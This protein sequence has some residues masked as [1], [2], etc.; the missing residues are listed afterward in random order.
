MGK[1]KGLTSIGNG[2]KMLIRLWGALPYIVLGLLLLIIIVLAGTC[3]AKKD[4]L[5]AEKNGGE[6]NERPPVNIV[7]LKLSPSSIRDSINLP[8]I[9]EPWVK[10]NIMAE[11]SGKV[12][13]KAVEEGQRVTKG[14]ILAVIDNRDYVNAYNS[15]KAV[16]ETAQASFNRFSKLYD[17]QLAT[18]S[19]LDTARASM[20]NAR[21]VMDNAALNVERCQIRAPFTGIVNNIFFEMGLY[22][23]VADPVAEMLQIDRVKVN[24]GI[25][26]SDV[27][28]VRKIKNFDIRIDALSGKTFRGIMHFLSSTADSSARLYSLKLAVENPGREILPDMFAR[29]EIVKRE[30]SDGIVIPLYAVI[31]RN[32]GHYA[33]VVNDGRA[34]I[35][36]VEIGL[37]ED[38]HV[39][40]TKGLSPDERVIVIGQ[41]SVE[42]EQKVNV[43]RDIESLEEL[44]K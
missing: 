12:I 39:E 29:I 13:Q 38:W 18:K 3:S 27:E 28:A 26:E 33:Y 43:I 16:Y 5:D 11:V 37:Q 21:S 31:T 15:G 4:R 22:M 34:H 10:L 35:R 19:Q 6:A 42:D 44:T 14:D 17:E 36:K 32:G 24:V 2:R 1:E 30:V 40:I 25:P 7:A 23:N 41:R 8:G 20:E 9:V